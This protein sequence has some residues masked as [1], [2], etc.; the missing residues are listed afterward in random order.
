V[1]VDRAVHEAFVE[2]CRRSGL[3]TCDVIEVFER[4]F[5]GKKFSK[6]PQVIDESER[7]DR[8]ERKRE[9][10]THTLFTHMQNRDKRGKKNVLQNDGKRTTRFYCALRDVW[11]EP[12]DLPLGDCRGCPNGACSAYVFSRVV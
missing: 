12:G 7:S 4:I 11:V 5:L 10:F 3:R 6:L 2:E 9:V 8:V 1:R